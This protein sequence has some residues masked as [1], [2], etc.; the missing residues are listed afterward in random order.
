MSC[1][2]ARNSRFTGKP[3][4]H[5]PSVASWPLV[6]NSA[7]TARGE[8]KRC[9][10]LCKSVENVR[11]VCAGLRQTPPDPKAFKCARALVMGSRG[12]GDPWASLSVSG[13]RGLLSS[14]RHSVVTRLT[15]TASYA[16][17][18]PS[19]PGWKGTLAGF[20]VSGSVARS[21]MSGGCFSFFSC[22]QTWEIH[23][24]RAH[25]TFAS[26]TRLRSVLWIETQA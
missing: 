2:R 10:S 23:D 7:Q 25:Q 11:R 24:G 26:R 4:V 22:M 13:Y 18:S 15:A 20:K 6:W 12:G 14:E 16:S 21:S 9:N 19:S 3:N 8:R 1:A 17:S 5:E